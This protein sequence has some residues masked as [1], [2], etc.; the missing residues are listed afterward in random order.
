MSSLRVHTHELEPDTVPDEATNE[1]PPVEE[2][3]PV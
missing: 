1:D 3:D 2:A